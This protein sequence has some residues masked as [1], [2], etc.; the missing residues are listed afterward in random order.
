MEKKYDHMHAEAAAQKLWQDHDLYS[1]Q[2]NPGP[3][4]SIDTP[5]LPYLDR[6]ISVIFSPIHKP[7]LLLV[8]NG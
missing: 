6:S 7:I 8:I 4:Y 3:L 2:H 1:A 5:L